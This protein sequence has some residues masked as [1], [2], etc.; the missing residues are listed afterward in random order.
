MP[1]D[2]HTTEESLDRSDDTQV[3][4]PCERDD[5]KTGDDTYH[6][7]TT[8]NLPMDGGPVDSGPMDSGQTQPQ[9]QGPTTMPL[10]LLLTASN[11]RISRLLTRSVMAARPPICLFISNMANC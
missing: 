4:A 3:T 2:R 10:A 1:I 11:Q 9:A 6:R 8:T 7:L 5:G